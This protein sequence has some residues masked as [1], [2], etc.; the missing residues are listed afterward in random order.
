MNHSTIT[1]EWWRFSFV[2]NWRFSLW[3]MNKRWI[4][5]IVTRSLNLG[6]FFRNELALNV[7]P[8]I[9]RVRWSRL[10][11]LQ[12]LDVI[13]NH[14]GE[15]AFLQFLL[16]IEGLLGFEKLLFLLF[17]LIEAFMQFRDWLR[18]TLIYSNEEVRL[19]KAILNHLFS[20][21]SQVNL[22]Q[23]TWLS[24]VI[25]EILEWTHTCQLFCWLLSQG[26]SFCVEAF[27]RTTTTS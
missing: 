12:K 24:W 19:L 25:Y 7:S 22:V 18:T 20:E 11:P 2:R 23:P 1:V 3:L 21:L 15:G 17:L 8:N 14:W 6:R 26:M 5:V 10:L 4:V 16:F 13:V 27:L 9:S